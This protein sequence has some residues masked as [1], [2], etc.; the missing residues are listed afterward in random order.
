MTK[1]LLLLAISLMLF[2]GCSNQESSRGNLFGY[3]ADET[4]NFNAKLNIEYANNKILPNTVI[5]IELNSSGYLQF[6]IRGAT[7]YVVKDFSREVRAGNHFFEWDLKNENGVL[8]KSGV[9]IMYIKFN[10]I[11]ETKMQLLC[12]T[13]KE[14][15]DMF[16]N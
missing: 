6:E 4:N 15:E 14:C 16:G 13:E 9:Y 10:G 5:S 12:M 11:I 1:Q 8:I 7:G 3:S 2:L